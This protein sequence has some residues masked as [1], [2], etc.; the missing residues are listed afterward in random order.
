[1]GAV[2]P[3]DCSA[4]AETVV[5]TRTLPSEPFSIVIADDEPES[6]ECLGDFVRAAGFRPVLAESGE[7]AIDIVRCEPVHLLVCDMYMDRLTGLE[8]LQLARQINQALPCILVTAALDD[9]L[10]QEALQA[11]AYSVLAKPVRKDVFLYT[12]DRALTRR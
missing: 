4:L 1:M 5:M 10:V 6:R 8:T 2:H 3:G 11:Q 12:V 7:V 9:R